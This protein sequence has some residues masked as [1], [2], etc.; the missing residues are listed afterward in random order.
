MDI[1]TIIVGLIIFGALAYVGQILFGKLKSFS[2]KNSSC[3][4]NCGCGT[5]S[6]AKKVFAQIKR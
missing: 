5:E 1:Q 2:A 3:A 4:A 6:G